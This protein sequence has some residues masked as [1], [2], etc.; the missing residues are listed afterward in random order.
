MEDKFRR[1]ELK[2]SL[3]YFVVLEFKDIMNGEDK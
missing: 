3:E 2:L 1:K